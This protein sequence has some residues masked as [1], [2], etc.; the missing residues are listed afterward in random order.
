[1]GTIDYI[2]VR[3]E[4]WPDQPVNGVWS[5]DHFGVVAELG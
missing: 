2:F 4:R 3:C 5:S 1:V